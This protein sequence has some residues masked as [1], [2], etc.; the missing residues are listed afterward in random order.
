LI[1]G[2]GDFENVVDLTALGEPDIEDSED[3]P[4]SNRSYRARPGYLPNVG[5]DPWSGSATFRGRN[6]RTYSKWLT[7]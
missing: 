7:W 5:V 4:V 3:F 6:R 1:D 2:K